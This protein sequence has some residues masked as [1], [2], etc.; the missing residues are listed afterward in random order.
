MNK[1]ITRIAITGA[2][3]RMGQMLVKEIQKNKKTCLST[4]VVK[5]NHPLINHDIGKIVGIGKTEVLIKDH[6]DVEKN[7]FDVLI[8]FTHPIATLEYLKYCN[9]FRKKII[10]GTTGFS[11]LEIKKI[12]SYSKNIA[13]LISSNFSIGINLL[14][15]L[16]EQTTRILGNNSDIDIIDFHHRNKIDIPSGTALTIGENISKVM[17]W[18]LNTNS[19]YYKKGLTKIRESKK[20][21]FSSI[22]SGGIIGKH[23]VIFTNS[24]EEIK[25]THTAFNRKSFAKGAIESAIW[26]ISKEKGLFNMKDFLKNM[27]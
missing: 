13:L 10:I 22:R 27:F 9:I 16:V 2:L 5:K 21:G 12:K 20:I 26:I 25:I 15:Q 19:L 18:N 14:C 8:D 6:L 4:V 7:D 1:K 3:G 11:D 17:K 23:S 24:E